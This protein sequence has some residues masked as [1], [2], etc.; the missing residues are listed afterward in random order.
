[1]NLEMFA[2]KLNSQYA[3]LDEDVQ[4]TLTGDSTV[5]GYK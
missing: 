4:E 5:L 3:I 2:P 1:M